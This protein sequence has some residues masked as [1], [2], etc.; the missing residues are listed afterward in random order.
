VPA[1]LA[2][3]ERQRVPPGEPAQLD[4]RWGDRR[5]H[6][7]LGGRSAA[8]PSG[9]H[10]DQPV[11]EG[12]HALHPVLGEDDGGAEVV[13]EAGEHPQHVLGGRRVQGGRRLVEDQHPRVHGEHGPDRDALLLATGQG[14]QRPRPELGDAEHVER[15]LD[16][17][18]HRLPPQTELLH[19]VGELVLH[20]LGHEARQRVLP[21]VPDQVR[22]LPRRPP[23]DALAAQQDVSTQMAAGE[24][25]DQAVDAGQ[26]RRLPRPGA[27][28]DE[29]QLGLGDPQVGHLQGRAVLPVVGE[30][31]VPPLDHD[32]APCLG[33]AP[34]RPVVPPAAAPT[35]G[36]GPGSASG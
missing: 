8:D 6:E 2:H 22:Q 3:G 31:D 17:A 13:D 9:L 4:H 15:L 28:G 35:S 25:R 14:P 32:V 1:R 20:D 27:A 36:P 23:C 5:V 10:D 26:Q 34:D 7:Q 19:P 11:G 24:V 16:A 33:A 18:A 29:D 30:A 12:D 21:D